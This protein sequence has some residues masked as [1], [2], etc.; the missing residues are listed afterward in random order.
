MRT[1]TQ[2]STQTTRKPNAVQVAAYIRDLHGTFEEK[3][4]DVM[5]TYGFAQSFA[6]ALV[7]QHGGDLGDYERV[8]AA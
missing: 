3:V 2:A 7:I 4:A 1:N 6:E 8:G 5:A